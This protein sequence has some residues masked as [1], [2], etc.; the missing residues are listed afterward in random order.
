M[1]IHRVGRGVAITRFQRRE[2]RAVF[3]E[4]VCKAP[5]GCEDLARTRQG[6]SGRIH[7][8]S[9][10]RKI[11]TAQHHLVKCQVKPMKLSAIT[12]LD[13]KFLIAE[14]SLKLEQPFI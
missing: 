4:S 8:C 1:S 9:D 12:S 10:A 6:P 3:P 5:G 7:R 11:E 13:R 2:N 14:V